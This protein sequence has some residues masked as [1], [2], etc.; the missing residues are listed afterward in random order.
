MW[1]PASIPTLG[2][3]WYSHCTDKDYEV[4]S[5]KQFGRGGV[6]PHKIQKKIKTI[7]CVYGSNITI[8]DQ[9]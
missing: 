6:I 2:P 8:P 7:T 3:T 4:L 5:I 9:A 1:S